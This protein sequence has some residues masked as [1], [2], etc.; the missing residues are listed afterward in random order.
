MWTLSRDQTLHWQALL[1][2]YLNYRRET[3][4]KSR[5]KLDCV[6]QSQ[7]SSSELVY[8]RSYKHL[9]LDRWQ[10]YISL[11][12]VV[13]V[14]SSLRPIK[15]KCPCVSSSQ[16]S[17]ARYMTWQ[18]LMD[19]NCSFESAI[20]LLLDRDATRLGQVGSL[21]IEAIEGRLILPQGV[22][23]GLR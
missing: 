20:S 3:R 11:G 23:L 10:T 2:Y 22:N 6:K 1:E 9:E 4:F 15:I 5:R 17:K 21:L 14:K 8:Y 16:Y 18:I 12:L 7:K 13:L 19:S